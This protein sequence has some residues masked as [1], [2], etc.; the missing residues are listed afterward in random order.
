[1]SSYMV[2]LGAPQD[3]GGTLKKTSSENRR[4]IWEDLLLNVLPN[5]GI[6][7]ENS[8][9]TLGKTSSENSGGTHKKTS[10]ENSGLRDLGFRV[11]GFRVKGFRV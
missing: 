3:S 11:Q 2:R 1:M 10:S 8:G 7:S 4:R 5:I 9:G 6:R